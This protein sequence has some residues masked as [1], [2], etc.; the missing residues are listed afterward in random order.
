MLVFSRSLTSRIVPIL[1]GCSLAMNQCDGLYLQACD[2]TA[3]TQLRWKHTS[4]TAG[5]V[6]PLSQQPTVVMPTRARGVLSRSKAM[7]VVKSTSPSSTR[8]LQRQ[9]TDGYVR[10]A[11]EQGFRSRASFKLL[12][13]QDKLKFLKKGQ[14]VLDLGARP[15]GFSQVASRV[16]GKTGFVFA[17][18][19]LPIEPLQ[20]TDADKGA[21]P[22]VS[23]QATI[24]EKNIDELVQ[25]F[26]AAL[27]AERPHR[28]FDVVMSDMAPSACGDAPTDHI[29][30]IAL[31]TLAL[32]VAQRCLNPRTGAFIVKVTHG[33]EDVPFRQLL[34]DHFG[35]AR[36]LKPPASRSDSR[37][38]YLFAHFDPHQTRTPH[39]NSD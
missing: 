28:T 25:D 27:P 36:V 4:R 5:F 37:E 17:V 26:V 18:D 33:A 19:T 6:D 12:E 7:R 11:H 16:V 22:V 14:A 35:N 39:N 32:N 30:L 15:G 10:A 1:N 20:L 8:W 9:L 29:R 24:N 2:D 3:Q 23:M 13:M 34:K 38:C 31:A 21:C